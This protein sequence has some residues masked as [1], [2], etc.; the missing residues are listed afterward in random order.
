MKLTSMFAAAAAFAI[1]TGCESPTPGLLSA[2]PV[3][4]ANDTAIDDALLGTWQ[5]RG[6]KDLV[7]IVRPADGGGYKIALMSGGGVMGFQAQFIRVKDAEFL[8]LSPSDDNDFRIP[9]HAIMRL[10]IDGPALKWAFLDSDWLKQQA[11]ALLSHSADGKMQLFSP[12]AAVR[13]F[14]AAHGADDKAYGQVA[15]WERVQ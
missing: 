13:A 3:A 8:D 6:S 9:G 14:V 5:E 10:W 1:L 15:T 11:A 7:A 2:E 4:T 12:T